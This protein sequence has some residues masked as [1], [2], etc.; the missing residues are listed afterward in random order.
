MSCTLKQAKTKEDKRTFSSP[1]GNCFL[2]S[3]PGC[4]GPTSEFIPSPIIGAITSSSLRL[5]LSTATKT[6][7]VRNSSS[8]FLKYPLRAAVSTA[9]DQTVVSGMSHNANR[10]RCVMSQARPPKWVEEDLEHKQ[11]WMRNYNNLA[12]T[13]ETQRNIIMED[14]WTRQEDGNKQIRF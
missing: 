6:G 8:S 14:S 4:G 5:R 3:I 1:G 7:H 11:R 9:C 12:E 13:L 2:F 10:E